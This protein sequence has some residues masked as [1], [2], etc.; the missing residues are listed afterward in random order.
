[1]M[2]NA[3]SQSDPQYSHYMYNQMAYNPGSAGADE[4]EIVLNMLR[5]DQWVGFNGAP[6]TSNL[7]VS[8]PFTLFGRDHG[9]GLSVYL[10]E[11]GFNGDLAIDL[12]YA[13]K[14]NIGDGTLGLGINGGL[15]QWKLDPEG[16]WSLPTGAEY[17]NELP[18]RDRNINK[19][20]AAAGLFYKTDEIFLGL[21]ATHLLGTPSGFDIV[22]DGG[23]TSQTVDYF[24]SPHFYVNAG[25]I[26]QLTNP[27]FELF[28][29]VL[30]T[31]DAQTSK[32]DMNT[33]LVYNKRFWGGLSYRVGAAITGMAGIELIEN[34]KIGVAYDFGTNDIRE[35]A[36]EIYE[37]FATYSF[38]LSVEKVPKQYKSIRYL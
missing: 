38:S 3:F 32:L 17:D 23:G 9:A 11:W 35:H 29:S 20:D 8:A 25:Y 24:Y 15:K 7:N 31:S 30:I 5:R 16:E 18:I 1:M 26:F 4:N 19:F 2:F 28:P 33:T 22:T 37:F 36:P 27:A 6:S 34:L 12:S 13:F 10:D 21:S 14:I